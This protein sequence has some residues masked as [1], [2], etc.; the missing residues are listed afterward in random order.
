VRLTGYPRLYNLADSRCEVAHLVSSTGGRSRCRPL[1]GDTKQVRNARIRT[2]AITSALLVAWAA[3]ARAEP[4]PLEPE[5]VRQASIDPKVVHLEILDGRD[6]RFSRLSRAQGVSQTRVSGIVQDNTGFIWF[7]TQYGL[8]RYDGYS[9]RQFKHMDDDSGSVSQSYI[10]ILFKDRDG[11]LWVATSRIFDRY[12]PTTETFVH[13]YLDV[14]PQSEL[15]RQLVDTPRNISQDGDGMFWVSTSLGLYRVDPATGRAT[16][17]RHRSDDPGS[18][19]S[20]DVKSSSVDRSGTLWVATGEGLDAFDRRTTRVTMHV[21]LRE[22]RQMSMYQDRSGALWIIHESGNGLARLDRAS[23]KLTQ[24]SFAEHATTGDQLTGVSSIIEDA[25]GQLWIGTESDGLLRLDSSRLRAARYRNDPFNSESLAENRTTSLM[26]DREGNIWVGLGA[27]E[28]NYFTPRSG[29][30][31]PL[32][33]DQGN[34]ANL[35]EKLV[36]V[37]YED[38]QGTLWVGTTGALNRYERSTRTYTHFQIPSHESSSDVLSI[39]EDRSGALW[40][41]TSGQG[42]A[43]LDLASG[44]VE[45]LYRHA[46]SNAASL[47]NDTVTHLLVDHSGTLWATTL[48]GLNRYDP[49]SDSFRSF[50]VATQSG[51]AVYVSLMEDSKG[52]LWISGIGG[53]LHF[54]PSTERF[55]EFKEGV[56]VHG[57][58]VLAASNGEVWAGTQEGLYRIDPVT[59][60]SRLYTERDG[61]PGNAIS[62]LL[63]DSYR[64]IWISTT[65]GVSRFLTKT[66]IFRNYSVQDGLPGRDFTGWSACFRSPRGVLYFGGFAGAVEIDPQGV[67][68]SPLSPPV[69]LTRLELAG[70]PVQL[71]PGSL[72]KQAIGYTK[73]LRL[74][75]TQRSFSIEFAALSFRSPSTNRYRYRLEGLDTAWQEVGSDRRIASYTTLPP[76]A[77]VLHVQGATNRGPWSEPGDELRITIERP[78]WATWEFRALAITLGLAL[79]IAIYAYRLRQVARTLEIRFDE[80]ISERTRIARDL[81]DTLLQSFHGLLLQL[82]TAYKLLPARAEEARKTLGAAIDGAF[83]AVTQG[84]DAVQGLRVSTMDDNDLA[85]AIKML[86]EELAGQESALKPLTLRVDVSGSSQPLRPIVRDEVY[87]IAAEALR[88]AFRHAHATQIEVHLCYD[89]RQLRLRVRDDGKGIDPQFLR[90]DSQLG[91]YGIHGMRERAKL[92]DGTLAIWTAPLSGVEVELIIPASRAYAAARATQRGWLARKLFAAAASSE[93]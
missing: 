29:P 52:T 9:F 21:P 75:S 78:W 26:Q 5:A 89:E 77:Y 55:T 40:A 68:D 61:L 81:H 13:H 38:R 48:D 33:V 56:A 46:N 57:Y 1:C 44:K 92:M 62:C 6:V 79:V 10:R 22:P 24:Y 73:E 41:G 34:P 37:L 69:V 53:V 70:V 84:R 25:D 67:L 7:A 86:G 76:G 42:L 85:A 65:E 15:S 18:L 45:R 82:Q 32:P 90:E 4:A 64:D 12:D 71:G 47:S 93:P 51:S 83:Q 74:P 60:S 11:G 27:S 30:F 20:D 16:S 87:R 54:D 8:N 72:L 35:G 39:V 58:P 17:F 43:K 28:P 19:S 50:R 2:A 88:N 23:G 63:E 14:P 59:H 49:E 3:T 66:G 36:N 91:H 80:R 31:N